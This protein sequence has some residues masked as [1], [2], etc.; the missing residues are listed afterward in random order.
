MLGKIKGGRREDETVG[1][2]HCFGHA[3]EQAPGDYG[4]QGSLAC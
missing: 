3:F 1:W 2:Y 4:G